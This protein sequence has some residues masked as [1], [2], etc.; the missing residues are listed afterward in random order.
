L[1]SLNSRGWGWRLFL[2]IALALF[3]LHAVVLLAAPSKSATSLISD[4]IQVAFGLLATVATIHASLRTD[5]F[6]KHFWLLISAC[7]LLWTTAQLMAAYYNNI[8][9]S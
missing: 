4:S 2:C 7:F 6:G 1:Q 8:R 3:L 9:L 5:R